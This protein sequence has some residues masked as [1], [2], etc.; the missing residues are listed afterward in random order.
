MPKKRKGFSKTFPRVKLSDSAH[1]NGSRGTLTSK[2]SGIEWSLNEDGTYTFVNTLNGGGRTLYAWY[3]LDANNMPIYK[4][5][6]SDSPEFTYDLADDRTLTVKSFYKTNEADKKTIKI[7]S[8]TVLGRAVWGVNIDAIDKNSFAELL[9]SRILNFAGRNSGLKSIIDD[10]VYRGLDIS[11]PV[12]WDSQLKSD[13]SASYGVN[14]LLFLDTIYKA[15]LETG[16]GEYRKLILDY[17]VDWAKNNDIQ[18]DG[19]DQY[20]WHDDGTALRVQRISYYYYIWGNGLPKRDR[21]LLEQSLKEQ[22]ALLA[23]DDF[24]TEKHNHGLHQDI[25]LLSYS[26]LL[27]D[28]QSKKS[29]L[30]LAMARAME[31][32]RYVYTEDGVHKEHSPSYA[33]DTVQDVGF[34]LQ[35]L[36]FVAPDY[37]AKLN[38]L[39][40]NAEEY[41][42][43][44]TKPD[45]TLPALG[46]SSVLALQT[47]CAFME[48]NEEYRWIVSGSK[49]G[50]RPQNSHVFKEGGYGVIRSSWDNAECNTWM[51]FTAATFSNAHKHSDDLSFLL[52]SDGD[53]FTEAGKKDYNYSNEL[54]TY[55]YSG[56]AHNVLLIDEED[57]PVRTN[58]SGFRSIFPE[59]L[60]TQIINYDLVGDVPWIK[61]RQVRFNGVIQD[62]TVS[63][64]RCANSIAVCDELEC[65][66]PHTASTIYHLASDIVS[67]LSEAGYKLYRKD[68]LIAEIS[69]SGNAVC[70][71]SI[72]SAGEEKP[73]FYTWI[74]NEL[75]EE[76][77]EQG[78]VLKIDMDCTEGYNYIKMNV[79]LY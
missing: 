57:F 71:Y 61:G 18:R 78:D 2:S 16:N 59:A 46:D 20:I 12:T 73:P 48:N 62:R 14:A 11:I 67:E 49:K 40:V 56:Y 7:S 79:Q 64:D 39:L 42:V 32:L 9:K 51:L 15:Y 69:F 53:L 5:G 41:F 28:A 34:L 76:G 77:W 35:A 44:L 21:L 50:L 26:M 45:G 27:D 33:A 58:A 63:Y 25:A 55:A 8:K 1:A 23:S 22:A 3:V 37:A 4:S 17:I 29:Y 31:Y 72:I 75:P 66:Q 60:S 74:F 6:Y 54:T 19:D 24:Y 10:Q 47:S 38:E 70:T 52:Y 68:K 13:R 36:K 30:Q 43:Q 65:E